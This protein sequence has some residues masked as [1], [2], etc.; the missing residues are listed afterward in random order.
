MVN[1]I[2]VSDFHYG[3]EFREDCFDNVLSYIK[4]NKPDIVVL[5]GDVV[6]KGRR[7]QYESVLPYLEE[8]KNVSKL[9]VI[10]G[11][12]DAKSNGIILFERFIAPRRSKLILEDKD[13]LIIGIC[14]ARDD[15]SEGLIGDEQ[16]DWLGRQFNRVLENR[17]IALHHHTIGVPYSGRKHNTLPDAGELI[18]LCQLFEVDL[19]LHGHKHVPHAYVIGPTTFLYCGTSCSDKIRADEN[20]SFNHIILDKGDLDVYLINSDDL[21][22]NLLLQRRENRTKFVRPRRARIEH[23]L[24]SAVWDD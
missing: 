7:K 13:T 20:P 2:H 5:T 22:K 3:S 6:H 24:N 23:M 8:I 21:K 17:V 9:M 10:P 19:V 4:D 14:T 16:L 12:H 11:N 15:I 18:E 1:I